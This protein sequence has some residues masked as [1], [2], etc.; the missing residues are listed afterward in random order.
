MNVREVDLPSGRKVKV[1]EVGVAEVYRLQGALPSLESLEGDTKLTARET[2]RAGLQM[3]AACC[4]E[5]RFFFDFR[6]DEEILREPAPVPKGYTEMDLSLADF[7][8]LVDLLFEEL[9]QAKEMSDPLLET[10]GAS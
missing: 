8:H 10:A 2:M 9:N 3:I 4:V 6:E 5:P 1:K 7:R